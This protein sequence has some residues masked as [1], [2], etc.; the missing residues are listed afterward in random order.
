MRIRTRTRTMIHMYY[1]HVLC[2]LVPCSN[3]PCSLQRFALEYDMYSPCILYM[4]SISVEVLMCHSTFVH[5]YCR[6]EYCI[7]TLQSSS[8]ASS[9]PSCRQIVLE[10]GESETT[11]AW[12]ADELC[13][14]VEGSTDYF[15]RRSMYEY[16]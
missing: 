11:Q 13:K 15:V 12:V 5:M 4:G 6:E 7:F 3:G 1:V 16:N 8:V 14:S 2:L 9:W 10:S